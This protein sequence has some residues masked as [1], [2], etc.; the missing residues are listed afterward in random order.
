MERNNHH[1]N[2]KDN[3]NTW[4]KRCVSTKMNNGNDRLHSF[5]ICISEYKFKKQ[6][7][8]NNANSKT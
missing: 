3:V 8:Q 7:K 6:K 5:S 4:M 2:D 1:F